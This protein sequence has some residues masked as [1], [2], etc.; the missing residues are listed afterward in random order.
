MK[1]SG[2]PY[3]DAT[4]EIARDGGVEVGYEFVLAFNR[5]YMDHFVNL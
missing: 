1:L 5:V 3:A 2:I 4:H